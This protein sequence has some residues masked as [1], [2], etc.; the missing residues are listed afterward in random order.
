MFFSYFLLH[1]ATGGNGIMQLYNG[2][3]KE[4]HLWGEE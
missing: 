2:M 1:K 3:K 4:L